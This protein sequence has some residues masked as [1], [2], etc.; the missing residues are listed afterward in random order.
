VVREVA[1][2]P[3]E[4][5]EDERRGRRG[6]RGDKE[7]GVPAEIRFL[8]ALR[9]GEHV[10]FGRQGRVIGTRQL[11]DTLQLPEPIVNNTE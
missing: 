8:R 7:R 11:R 3:Y 10:S 6:D 2:Q 1:V 5:V 4:T 9:P